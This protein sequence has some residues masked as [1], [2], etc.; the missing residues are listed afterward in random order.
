MQHALRLG[1]CHHRMTIRRCMDQQGVVEFRS[2]LVVVCCL[3]VCHLLYDVNVT[4]ARTH[5]NAHARTG[6][7]LGQKP[8]SHPS[9][10]FQDN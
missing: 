1:A 2:C 8:N 9:D 4:H 6:H 5:I 3:A 7:R 10:T